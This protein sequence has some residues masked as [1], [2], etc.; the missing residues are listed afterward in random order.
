MREERVVQPLLVTSS[1]L[2]LATECVR[3]ILKARLIGFGVLEGGRRAA[4]A[5]GLGRSFEWPGAFC[6]VCWEALGPLV[7]PGAPV[8]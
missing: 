2:T 7:A 3:M 4:R 5:A 6:L 1:A 8:S